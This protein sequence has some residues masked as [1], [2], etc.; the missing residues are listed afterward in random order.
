MAAYE[1][2]SE[3]HIYFYG[4]AFSN[5]AYCP[6]GVAVVIGDEL[7]AFRTAEH[8]FSALKA[9][10]FGDADAIEQLKE[11]I[12][13]SD[14]KHIGRNV[15]GFDNNRWTEVHYD[16]MRTVLLAKFTQNENHKKSLLETDS[17]IIVEASPYDCLWGVGREIVDR[18]LY[19]ERTWRGQNLLGQCLMEVRDIIRQ[20]A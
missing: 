17:K 1:Q 4:G 19:S 12:R 7:I 8:A 10:K 14:A 18:R 13:P 15:R 5:F 9:Y 20:N 6:S 2:E 11:A 16:A 3:T